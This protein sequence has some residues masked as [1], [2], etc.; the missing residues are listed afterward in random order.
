MIATVNVRFAC[1]KKQVDN[2][3]HFKNRW[4]NYKTNG[5]KAESG[6]MENFKHSICKVTFKS[7]RKGFLKDS[8]VWLIDK[9]QDFDPAKREFY[10]MRHCTKNQVFY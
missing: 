9:A 3:D 5:G 2:T 6:N 4:N 7:N 10:W 8:E 1:S